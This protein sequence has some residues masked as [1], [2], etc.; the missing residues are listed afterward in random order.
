MFF[1]CK[2]IGVRNPNLDLLTRKFLAH[3]RMHF[4]EIVTFVADRESSVV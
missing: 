4:V 3:V 1:V 2:A